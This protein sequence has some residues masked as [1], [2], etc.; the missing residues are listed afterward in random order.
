MLQPEV[1]SGSQ[2][3]LALTL[4]IFTT[5][6]LGGNGEWTM[7]ITI[8][9]YIGTAIGIYSPLPYKAAV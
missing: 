4:Y 6:C 7:G 9:V 5:W 3:D 2:V 8:G 1:W